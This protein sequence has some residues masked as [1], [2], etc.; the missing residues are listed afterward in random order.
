MDILANANAIVGYN[1]ALSLRDRQKALEGL[2]VAVD[3]TEGY[4]DMGT[5]VPAGLHVRRISDGRMDGTPTFYV[6]DEIDNI[7]PL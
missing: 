6:I 4:D 5:T 7:S 1:V 2:L 3:M